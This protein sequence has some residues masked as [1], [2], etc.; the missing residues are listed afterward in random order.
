MII[1]KGILMRNSDEDTQTNKK[2]KIKEP[3]YINTSISFFKQKFDQAFNCFL[4]KL[5]SLYLN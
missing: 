5:N 3:S 4:V 1:L 2:N